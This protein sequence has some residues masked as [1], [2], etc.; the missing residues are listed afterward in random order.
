MR[1]LQISN[2]YFPHT[3]GIEQ[4]AWD[5]AH[6]LDGYE[7]KVLC[8]NH[9]KDDTD[10]VIDGVNVIRAGT[11]AKVASQS[12]SFSYYKVMKRVFNDFQPDVVIF[13]YPN[14]FVAHYLLKILKKRKNCKLVLWWHLDITKQKLLGKLFNGQTRRLLNRAEKIVATSPNYV[15]GSKFLS[16]FKDKCSVICNCFND[17]RV[18]V[19][20]NNHK[21]AL[22]IKEQN[23]GKTICFAVGR[24][25]PY[26]GIEHLVQASKY[27]SEDYAIYIGGIGP[28]TE[29]L[30]EK[31]KGDKKITFLGRVSD[32]ELKEYML[33]C[34]VF[35]FPSITKNEAFGIALA[36]AMA[37]GNACVTFTIEGSG[38]NYVSINGETG[39]EVPNG[40]DKKFALAIEKLAK[41]DVLRKE[42]AAHAKE[43]A[44]K[45]FTYREF[46]KKINEFFS[47]IQ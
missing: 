2:Y 5:I 26:K 47:K 42:Y 21:N 27:L 8:F 6:A 35:C 4:V 38:V 3:G 13:H 25:V 46:A 28:L 11:F 22:K 9:E 32:D 45:L 34:D 17:E 30:K 15:E 39:I 18:K 24:H 10:D 44:L 12:L 31:A 29:E 19:D 36:E 1:I 41:D 7:N 40:D 23:A 37:F 20:D 43:R 14:P 33:A 16:S